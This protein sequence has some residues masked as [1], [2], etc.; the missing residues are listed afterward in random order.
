[1]PT[2]WRH[3]VELAGVEG[4]RRGW[5][6][7]STSTSAGEFGRAPGVGARVGRLAV[8]AQQPQHGAPARRARRRW[9]AGW[10]RAPPWPASGSPVDDVG[11][12]ARLHV[13]RGHGV[14]DAVVQVAGDAQPVLG[15]PPAGL[16]LPGAFELA[17]PFP[18]APRGR[19][20]GCARHHR[21]TRPPPP[22]RRTPAA[23]AI[24]NRS[25]AS[26]ID[27]PQ[28]AAQRPGADRGEP[29]IGPPARHE[30]G[31]PSPAANTG[32]SGTGGRHRPP[33]PPRRGPGRAAAAG[34]SGP[35]SHSRRRPT[36]CP[37]RPSHDRPRPEPGGR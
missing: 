34:G 28:N 20:A 30:Q 29:A 23:R 1:M 31:P 2:G 24:R 33:A 4:D 13:D 21:A 8:V 27:H 5:A 9:P 6:A 35:T 22:R 17:G 37:A 26:E 10:R 36:R 7:R 25:T 19:R 12:R 3:G 18:R 11:G 14:G 15:D 32:P 16:L